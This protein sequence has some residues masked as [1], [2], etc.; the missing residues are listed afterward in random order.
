M[1]PLAQEGPQQESQDPLRQLSAPQAQQAL[2]LRE[3]KQPPQPA[4]VEGPQGP[5]WQKQ[6]LSFLQRQQQKP[7]SA[8]QASFWGAEELVLL[9]VGRYETEGSPEEAQPEPLEA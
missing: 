6:A 8:W 5:P 2:C 7:V 1:V 9:L 3:L 4:D